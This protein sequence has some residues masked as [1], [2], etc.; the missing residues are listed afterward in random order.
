MVF[1]G[2]A[3]RRGIDFALRSFDPMV[4]AQ[5]GLFCGRVQL[6][7]GNTARAI[8][9]FAVTLHWSLAQGNLT[10]SSPALESMVLA[11]GA[12]P[13]RV[14]IRPATALVLE[15]RSRPRRRGFRCGAVRESRGPCRG[16]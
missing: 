7:M 2:V 3:Y 12:E 10:M 4:S 11:G 15:L 5:C 13:E 9:D 14:A 16:A 8:E 1:W 6:D